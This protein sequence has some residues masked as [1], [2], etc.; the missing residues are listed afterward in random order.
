MNQDNFFSI[1][2]LM[3]FGLGMG[4]AQQM[5]RVMNQTMSTMYVPG[6]VSTIPQP[7]TQVKPIYVDLGGNAAGPFTE[8]EFASLVSRKEVT[9]STLIW[10]PGM[11]EWQPVE[12]VPE[13]L[14][15]IALTPPPLPE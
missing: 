10:Q 11:T 9:P 7:V 6:S 14:K 15:I 8:A 13:A 5:I 2:R 12:R 4:M 3:E 1:D